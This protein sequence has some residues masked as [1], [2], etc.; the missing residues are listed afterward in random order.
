[1]VIL[2][3]FME[4]KIFNILINR[5]VVRDSCLVFRFV[6][7]HSASCASVKWDGI[8]QVRLGVSVGFRQPCQ[9]EATDEL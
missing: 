7:S 3:T 6:A 4:S 1:M 9:A 5:H 8:L 2:L